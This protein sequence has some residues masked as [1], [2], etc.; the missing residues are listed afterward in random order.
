MVVAPA[1]GADTSVTPSP[2]TMEGG[3]GTPVTTSRSTMEG[4]TDTSVETGSETPLAGGSAIVVSVAVRSIASTSKSLNGLNRRS[5]TR[6]LPSS[7]IQK[8]PDPK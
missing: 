5:E 7:K 3:I 8:G 1:G 4:G 2:A 6:E